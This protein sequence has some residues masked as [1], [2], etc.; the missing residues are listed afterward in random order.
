MPSRTLRR[1]GALGVGARLLGHRLIRR[2]ACGL[3]GRDLA[4]A[5]D[6]CGS[7]PRPCG[8][9]PRR[10][11][12]SSWP[13]TCWKRRLN[14]SCLAS[15]SRSTS[16]V[17][18]ELAELGVPLAIRLTS[19]RGA[20][21]NL[22]LI[23]SFWMA[24]SMASWASVSCDAGQLEHDPAGLHDGDPALGVALARAHAGLGRLLGDGLVGEDV[25]PDLAAALDVA[26]HGDTGGLDL[27]GGDPAR[28]EGLDAVVAEGDRGAALGHARSMRP[29]CCLRCLT[30]LGI[31]MAAT[32]PPCGSAGSRG[33]RGCGARS[34]LPRRAGARARDRPP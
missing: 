28:L 11:V 24:R 13:V 18:V 22:A 16:S 4:L 20:A 27:A 3:G 2:S 19:S 1:L 34:P 29:R 6:R 31:N 7:G 5:Q 8:P 26:G 30:F 21:T 15:A 14:S 23:G 33:A 12:L 25:D 17:V 9:G 10:A 32:R